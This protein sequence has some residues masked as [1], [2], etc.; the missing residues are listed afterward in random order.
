MS[1]LPSL[2]IKYFVWFA[3]SLMYIFVLTKF[4]NLKI[5]RF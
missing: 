3:F 5:P 1:Q 2:A 4:I